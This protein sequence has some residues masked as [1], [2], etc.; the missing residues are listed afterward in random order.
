MTGML[1][2]T[3]AQALVIV[4]LI[5]KRGRRLN[6]SEC[7]DRSFLPLRHAPDTASSCVPVIMH[8]MD[9]ARRA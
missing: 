5:V 1:F 8:V 3:F 9:Y 2:M 6:R 4:G 7:D